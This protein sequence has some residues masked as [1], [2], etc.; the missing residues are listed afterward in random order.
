MRSALQDR[1]RI[2]Q[3]VRGERPWADVRSI[4]MTVTL[5]PTGYVADVPPGLDDATA[6][7]T[8][9][10]RGLLRHL[11]QPRELRAWAFVVLTSPINLALEDNPAGE[12]LL[13]ALHAASFGEP[14]SEEAVAL[15]KRSIELE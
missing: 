10:A 3:I 2:L 7:A 12:T 11:A 5:E 15:A 13:D 14:V 4:G 9:V 6:G 8:D 1:Q